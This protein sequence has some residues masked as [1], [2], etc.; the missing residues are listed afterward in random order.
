MSLAVHNVVQ[1]TDADVRGRFV[2]RHQE[3]DDLLTH[4]HEG[5]PPR[6][7]LVIGRRGMGKSLLLRRVAITVT[8]DP[9]LAASHRTDHGR[10][11]TRASGSRFPTG[12]DGRTANPRTAPRSLDRSDTGPK[13]PTTHGRDPS[14]T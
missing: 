9:D 4:L 5:D 14:P 3:L 7:A 13:E 11:R 8:D 2:V 6:H 1:L 10:C 12:H